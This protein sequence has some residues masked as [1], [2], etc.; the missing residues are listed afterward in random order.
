MYEKELSSQFSRVLDRYGSI[1]LLSIYVTLSDVLNDIP[2]A[3][4]ILV[5]RK[6]YQRLKRLDELYL[7]SKNSE[8]YVCLKNINDINDTLIDDVKNLIYNYLEESLDEE[9][10]EKKSD[11][12][13]T[14]FD[15]QY[16]FSLLSRFHCKIYELVEEKYQQCFL[17][18]D[19]HF[20]YMCG[21]RMDSPDYKII[22]QQLVQFHIL[23]IVCFYD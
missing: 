7:N 23:I 5:R 16:T 20:L 14:S 17:T 22:E 19:E 1:G 15:I 13:N 2:S 8:A 10:D 11:M 18:S 4:N 9:N 3:S 12:I 6:V 21:R